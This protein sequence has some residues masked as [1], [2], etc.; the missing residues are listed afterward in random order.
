MPVTRYE[1]LIAHYENSI[2][3]ACDL[4]EGQV[5]VANGGGR[6]RGWG[7]PSP[8]VLGPDH[9]GTSMTAG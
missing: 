3:H 6:R 8:F 7:I 9:G 5:F 1:D 4:E 2:S